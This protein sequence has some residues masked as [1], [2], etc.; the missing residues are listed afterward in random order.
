M[1]VTAGAQPLAECRVSRSYKLVPM[2]LS[3]LS[4]ELEYDRVHGETNRQTDQRIFADFVASQEAERRRLASVQTSSRAMSAPRSNTGTTLS[5]EMDKTMFLEIWNKNYDL[6]TLAQWI[7]ENHTMVSCQAFVRWPTHG[8]LICVYQACQACTDPTQ[9]VPDA[10]G[11][12]PRCNKCIKWKRACSRVTA[13]KRRQVI[14]QGRWSPE[15][16]D[17][18]IKGLEADKAQGKKAKGR[19][20]TGTSRRDGKGTVARRTRAIKIKIPGLPLPPTPSSEGMGLPLFIGPITPPTP[21][22]GTPGPLLATEPSEHL[23]PSPPP[24]FEDLPNDQISQQ[25]GYWHREQ[26]K[27]LTRNSILLASNNHMVSALCE[28]QRRLNTSNELIES[29]TKGEPHD[30][31]RIDALERKLQE[32]D[33]KIA[34]LKARDVERAR[35]LEVRQVEE[36]KAQCEAEH[37]QHVRKLEEQHR[38]QITQARNEAI[39]QSSVKHILEVNERE[40]RLA[41]V[42]EQRLAEQRDQLEEQYLGQLNEARQELQAINTRTQLEY[43]RRLGEQ[44]QEV[45]VVRGQCEAR[46]KEIEEASAAQVAR[47]P[48]LQATALRAD[49]LEREL[50]GWHLHAD[51][52]ELAAVSRVTAMQEMTRFMEN[53][54]ATDAHWST[55]ANRLWD[56][57][58][59]DRAATRKWLSEVGGKAWAILKD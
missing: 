35:K 12:S 48:D 9:C 58:I 39:A 45:E 34:Q 10:S 50:R 17:E 29:L 38:L 41:K 19:A 2:L 53:N 54:V 21:P 42:H 31:S 13:Y 33:V 51:T 49:G 15:Q 20:A 14:A 22:F 43:T 32:T 59:N 26:H 18:L 46:L 4:Q 36:I 11:Q 16:V 7:E 23:A 37:A 8:Y 44:Q 40:C 47:L 27:L 1:E 56:L 5:D 55:L 28:A 25:I 6:T 57:Y 30:A 24:P 3:R 52:L